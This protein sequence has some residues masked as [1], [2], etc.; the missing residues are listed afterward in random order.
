M[1]E[2]P[3]TLMNLIGLYCYDTQVKEIP[4]TLTK[5]EGLSCKQK[6]RVKIFDRYVLDP[7]HKGKIEVCR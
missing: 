4:S 1:K 7:K 3:N 2:I 5:L 6:H